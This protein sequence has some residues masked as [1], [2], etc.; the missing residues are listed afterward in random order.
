MSHIEK[1]VAIALHLL[2]CSYA[3]QSVDKVL[4]TQHQLRWFPLRLG[5]LI[6]FQ[7]QRSTY[8]RSVDQLFI[9]QFILLA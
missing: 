2:F 6:T 1:E 4:F 8:C 5:D 3:G 7:G 9:C